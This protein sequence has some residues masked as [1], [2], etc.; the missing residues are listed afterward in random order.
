M[1]M[2][3]NGASSRSNLL[4]M[5]PSILAGELVRYFMWFAID[6]HFLMSISN[7]SHGRRSLY[8]QM[9]GL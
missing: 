9:L 2:N 7:Y 4:L 1:A 8:N 3:E 6:G 5:R